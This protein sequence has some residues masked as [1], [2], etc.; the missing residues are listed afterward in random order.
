MNFDT[1]NGKVTC[2]EKGD[3]SC[4]LKDV[5]YNPQVNTTLISVINI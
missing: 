4:T 1:A 5:V 2:H 3:I